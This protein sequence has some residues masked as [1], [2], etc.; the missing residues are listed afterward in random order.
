MTCTINRLRRTSARFAAGV[1]QWLMAGIV[2][3]TA[4]GS[5]MLLWHVLEPHLPST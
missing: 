1:D 4:V 5:W 2:L 3:M